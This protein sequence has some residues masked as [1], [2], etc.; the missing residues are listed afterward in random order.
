[1]QRGERRV[2][3]R[4]RFRI[5]RHRKMH[6]L[7]APGHEAVRLGVG[8][9]TGREG[10]RDQRH[11]EAGSRTH[12]SSPLGIAKDLYLADDVGTRRILTGFASPGKIILI[13][14]SEPL[15]DP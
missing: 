9:G 8:S 5:A 3:A 6:V 14:D 2:E 11:D 12:R 7:A 1:M 13:S 15:L 10:S 4:L